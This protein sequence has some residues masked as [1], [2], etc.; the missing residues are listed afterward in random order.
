M[1]AAEFLDTNVLVYAY[2]PDSV[3][4]PIAR[5]LLEQAVAGQCWISAQVLA[6]FVAVLLHKVHS[7]L[8]PIRVR[9]ILDVISPIPLVPWRSDL[10]ARAAEAHGKFGI[11]FYDGLIVAA[12][13]HAGCRRIW[14][15]DLKPGQRYFGIEIVNPFT[16]KMS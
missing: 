4:A 3:K 13:E 14:S 16:P 12:A 10:V 2:S 1:N 11:H 8:E 15:E 7:P 6:E 5:R 9:Q